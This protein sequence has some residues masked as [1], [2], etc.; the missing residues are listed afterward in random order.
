[1]KTF[2]FKDIQDYIMGRAQFPDADSAPVI[3]DHLSTLGANKQPMSRRDFLIEDTEDQ[4]AFGFHRLAVRSALLKRPLSDEEL[5]SCKCIAAYHP[6]IWKL[7]PT[8]DSLRLFIELTP[9]LV[10]KK[11][12]EAK[13]FLLE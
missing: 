6:S 1:M 11:Q 8:K 5:Y 9:Y 10:P 12:A 3:I 13:L 4:V 7:L 2:T